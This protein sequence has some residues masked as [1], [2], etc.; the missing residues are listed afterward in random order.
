VT[1]RFSL[2]NTTMRILMMTTPIRPEP[3]SFPPIAV[4]SIINY[5]RKNG[6]DDVD[7]LNIDGMRP[8][9]E[10]VLAHIERTRPEVIG[11]S[12][13]V[14][15]AY[16]YT[17]RLTLD[18]K[19]LLPDTLVVVGGNLA[20]S[21]E[22]LLKKTGT[23]LCVVGEGEIT[24]LEIVRRA[25]T[26]R[27]PADF[28]DI[29]SVVLLRDGKLINTGYRDQ[30]RA[31]EV[32]D[33]CWDD[34]E[35]SGCLSTYVKPVFGP[36]G[37]SELFLR[38][39]RTFEPHRRDK[40]EMVISV[41]KGCVARC[42]F[43]HRWDKGIRYIPVPVLIERI[44]DAIQ[45]YNVGFIPFAAE[46]FSADKRW[47]KEF[48]AA[49]KP[50]DLLWASNGIRA[51]AIDEE[52]VH[53]MKDAGC[54]R[55]V[56]GN[57]TGSAKMLSIMEKKISLE[58]NYDAVRWIVEADLGTSIQLVLGMPG[59]SPETVGETIEYCKKV[60]TIS[61]EQNPNDLSINYAQALPGTP[62]YE[63]GRRRG[64]IGQSLE[65]EE[66]YLLNISD[67]NAHDETNTLNFTDYPELMTRC[68]RPL[69]TCETSHHFI[70]KFGIDTYR[71]VIARDSG[72]LADDTGGQGYFAN[73]KRLLDEAPKAPEPPPLLRLLAKRQF[74]LAMVH[75]PVLFYRLRRLLP[76]LVLT[77]SLSSDGLRPTLAL[78]GE[79][80]HWRIHR[81]S[82]G[83]EKAIRYAS[84]RK[85]VEEDL[86]PVPGDSEEMVPLRKGR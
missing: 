70:C 31:A 8:R 69:I 66:E 78:I 38:D 49:I 41:G 2:W 86:P 19:R 51:N 13:V 63:F 74:G 21:S 62:L 3:T 39:P 47:L 24:F 17:R 23:D 85:V 56:C 20:A 30:L 1:A 34:L 72:V 71:R 67:T 11:I 54:V 61:R 35:R 42:T 64:L 27:R 68:W 58:D 79:Y 43:C 36:N 81:L 46:T 32:Y 15:T 44:K 59:E 60:L 33:V 76:L 57:E 16:A 14:S 40:T 80:V 65:A 83:E 4:L 82:G 10:D 29:V 6:I 26:T 53:I 9:Y 48:C 73:P 7:F 55:L 75:Y 22:I 45:R 28:S 84:L 18:I 52:W 50:L 25:E 77:K 37:P 5:L 12:A